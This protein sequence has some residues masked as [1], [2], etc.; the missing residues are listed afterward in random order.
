MCKKDCKAEAFT[1]KTHKDLDAVR[2]CFRVKQ[3]QI[4]LRSNVTQQALVESLQYLEEISDYLVIVRNKHLKSLSFLRRLRLIKGAR[5]FEKKFALFVHTNELLRELWDY[6]LNEFK[7]ENG[8]VKFFE[9]PELCYEEIEA[10]MHETSASSMDADVSFSFNGYR[11][12][13]CSNRTVDL[14]FRLLPKQVVVSWSVSV[15][16]LRRLKGFILSYVEVADGFVFEQN[17]VDFMHSSHKSLNAVAD[18]VYEW[19]YVYLQ[20]DEYKMSKVVRASID[21]E[22]FTRYA[23]YVKADLTMDTQWSNKSSYSLS[24]GADRLISKINY[25]YSLPAREYFFFNFYLNK[26][27]YIS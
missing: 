26:E 18:S 9:N 19:N 3:L 7:I 12:L 16:D 6:K 14:S 20:Y 13:T 11:R 22:P 2:N 15:A 4:E 24:F 1:L 21:V 17:D 10:F 25:V 23:V 5:L 8:T 27:R